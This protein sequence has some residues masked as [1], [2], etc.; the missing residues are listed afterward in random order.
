MS[1]TK[2]QILTELYGSIQ[3]NSML[4]KF[5]AG[6]GSEDLKAELFAVLCEKSDEQIMDLHNK[7][8]LMYFATGIVQRM[9]FQKGS[10]FHRLYRSCVYEYTDAM[11]S[12]PD[13]SLAKDKEQQI[14]AMEKGIDN[15][16]WVEQRMLEIW[17][18]E[19]DMVSITRKTKIPYRQVQNIIG[20]AKKKLMTEVSGKIFGNYIVANMEVVI[21]CEE[22]VTPDNIIDI[23]EAT[24]CY[25]KQQVEGRQVPSQK[26][27]IKDLK[28]MRVKKII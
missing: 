21:D 18:D 1:Y 8:Q 25:L 2:S 22:D 14:A 7:G 19:G 6:G 20:N 15:L 17:Q 28:P 23:L 3:L 11:L 27:F 26:S 24:L 10:K 16:H 4:S 12:A 9:I 13:E 5:N